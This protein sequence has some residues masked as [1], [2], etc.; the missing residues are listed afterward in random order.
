MENLITKNFRHGRKD[1]SKIRGT[2]KSIGSFLMGGVV[3]VG[4]ILVVL[5]FVKGGVWLGVKILPW[6]SLIIWPVLA[7]DI[8]II[9]PLGIF[10][11]T[12]E[13]SAIGLVV[14]S[15]VYGLTLWFWALLLTYSIWGAVAVFIGLFILGV[16]VVP[17]AMLATV[18]EGQWSILGQLMFLLF[19]IFGS[20]ALGYYFAHRAE[21]LAYEAERQRLSDYLSTT[22]KETG[23]DAG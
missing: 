13:V 8:L 15:W 10:K 20:R 6:L 11:K 16:G 23:D 2:L 21:E 17:I 14:S 3:F 12:K 22:E 1:Y 18:I 9:L 7:I 4:L 5:F 19:L